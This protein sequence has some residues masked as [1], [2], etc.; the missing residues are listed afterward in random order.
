MS[1]L[2]NSTGFPS[3]AVSTSLNNMPISLPNDDMIT[4]FI[5][6]TEPGNQRVGPQWL[7]LA[8][9][10]SHPS[11]GKSFWKLGIM[12]QAWSASI[13]SIDISSFPSSKL[14]NGMKLTLK[15]MWFQDVSVKL[16]SE[17]LTYRGGCATAVF[18]VTI[19]QLK[20]FLINYH[21][22]FASFVWVVRTVSKL[23][24]NSA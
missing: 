12:K 22:L 13:L 14:W 19:K 7:T 16:L 9:Q 8:S 2:D 21:F 5:L 11:T 6:H 1:K 20:P 10:L 18:G 3:E 24:T 15:Y 17:R 23:V 4:P